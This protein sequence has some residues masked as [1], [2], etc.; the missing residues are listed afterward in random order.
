MASILITFG[1]MDPKWAPC[2]TC[3]QRMN[4]FLHTRVDCDRAIYVDIILSCFIKLQSIR[5][6]NAAARLIGSR[7]VAIGL[8]IVGLYP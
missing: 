2:R 7:L 4:A 8:G 5:G 1:Y 3:R 6:L